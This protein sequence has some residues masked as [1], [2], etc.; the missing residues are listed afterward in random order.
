[1]RKA[2][3]DQN[4]LAARNEVGSLRALLEGTMIKLPRRV[5]RDGALVA[6]IGVPG[7]P[8]SR[9]GHV[10]RY[11]EAVARRTGLDYLPQ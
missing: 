2:G 3:A 9:V 1:M 11:L 8:D 10:H 7:R 4:P 5:E 6:I